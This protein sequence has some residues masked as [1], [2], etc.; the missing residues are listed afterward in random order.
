MTDKKNQLNSAEESA[1]IPTLVWHGEKNQLSP[2]LAE[3]KKCLMAFELPLFAVRDADGLKFT[4]SGELASPNGK[5]ANLAGWLP[6]LPALAMGDPSFYSTYNVKAA[7]YAGGMANAIASE[8]MVIAL[9]R[10]GLMGSFGSGG[11]SPDRLTKAVETIQTAVP[12]GPYMFNLLHN[13]FEPEMEQRTVEIFLEHNVRVVEAAAY[14]RLT[15]ALVQYRASGLSRGNSGEIVIENHVIAKLSRREISLHF[16][17]PAPEKILTELVNDGKISQEQAELAAH[18]PMADDITVEADSGGHTDN[19]PLVSLLPS[20]IALRDRT[21]SENRLETKVRIGAGGGISTPESTLGAFMMGA[22]Y[23]VT[24]SVNQACV[25]SGASEHTRKILAD[26]DMADVSMAPSADMFEQGS[27]VQ[28]LKK[29]TLF[30]MRAQKLYDIYMTYDSIE[31]IPAAVKNELE[32]RVFMRSMEQIWQ[33]TREFFTQRNPEMI[34]KAEQNPKK[35]MALI[36]RWYLGL[37]SR[38]SRDGVE[39]RRMDYQIWCGPS[40]GAF[41]EWARGTYLEDYRNRHVADVAWQLLR[42]CAYAYRVA[43]L[44]MQGVQVPAEITAYRPD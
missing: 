23:V 38:W 2:D 26:A 40:M 30:P 21:Q 29:G 43:A 39:D 14:L 10:E 42:G 5:P 37:A 11:L 19:Q 17:N 18:V 12:E 44:Q 41:N 8:E 34:T 3:I 24:G 33:D 36:F 9:A 7:Y 1:G 16:L 27:R 31:E 22:A 32:T 15:H 25:E 28:V 4:N 20:I 6:P 13:P 35:K